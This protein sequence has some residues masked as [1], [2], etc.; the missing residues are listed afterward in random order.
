MTVDANTW[1]LP[2]RR[3]AGPPTNADIQQ[4]SSGANAPTPPRSRNFPFLM[5]MSA[6][7][8]R[9]ISTPLL[10]GPAILRR[11]Y[12]VYGTP[13]SPPG[14]S[15]EIGWSP[16]AVTEAGVALT[17]VRP[18]TVLTEKLDPFAVSAAA[19][20]AG[21]PAITTPSGRA[22]WEVPCDYIVTETRFAFTLSWVNNSVSGEERDGYMTV[23]ENVNADALNLF[24]GS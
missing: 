6:N 12:F 17:T 11:V 9:T 22:F 15:L 10:V 5:T 23:I 24:T 19:I 18:Y 16:N 14:Q 13:S 21:Y 4:A 3:R 1:P 2:R 20:G 7:S 8:R